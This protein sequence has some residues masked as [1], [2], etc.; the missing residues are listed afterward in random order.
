MTE[1]VSPFEEPWPDH[2][3]QLVVNAIRSAVTASD[4]YRWGDPR[5]TDHRPAGS[6]GDAEGIEGSLSEAGRKWA[7]AHQSASLMRN[8]L[9]ALEASMDAESDAGTE[10]ERTA[11]LRAWRTVTDAATWTSLN[12]LEQAALVDPLT[13]VGNRRALDLMLTQAMS[14]AR[15]TGSGLVVVAMDLDGLKRINDSQGHAEG[16]RT[17]TSLVD[18]VGSGLRASDAVFR[19]GGDEFAVVLPGTGLGHVDA[20][21]ERILAGDT[22]RFTW[23]AAELTAEQQRPA[24]LLDAADTDLYRH[25][26]VER[27]LAAVGASAVVAGL[28]G[29][30]RSLRSRVSRRVSVAAAAGLVA[31]SGTLATVS[32][33]SPGTQTALSPKHGD[34]PP[35]PAGGS[36]GP[37]SSTTP[38]TLPTTPTTTPIITSSP[39]TPPPKATTSVVAATGGTSP[40]PVT[41]GSTSPHVQLASAVATSPTPGPTAATAGG[42][43]T[44]PSPSPTA[45]PPPTTTVPVAAATATR[46]KSGNTLP[47]QAVAAQT[48]ATQAATARAAVRA[49]ERSGDALLTQAVAQATA[50]L[51]AVVSDAIPAVQPP[52]AQVATSSID[53]EPP[54]V[55]NAAQTP[56][57]A[58]P[59]PP[60]PTPGRQSGG[61]TPVAPPTPA[62]DHPSDGPHG[63]NHTSS[64]RR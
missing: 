33:L 30:H 21:M 24:E 39:S 9:D 5:A 59:T 2:E 36:G 10:A 58:E 53:V 38:T 40:A 37:T 23:G 35:A 4:Q 51:A 29:S 3:T 43:T 64:R 16:D 49:A 7:L 22:P 61:R 63:G 8:R 34:K 15:R 44:G 45:A 18:A 32:T 27:D 26:G 60:I 6:A 14:G 54:A 50:A 52:A 46:G 11:Y 25:R 13:G 20:L 41:T 42:T 55:V 12:Q 56:S 48:A 47:A 19:T 57:S 28:G 31:I 62:A 17:L 1:A